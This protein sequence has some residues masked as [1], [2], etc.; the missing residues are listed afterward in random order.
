MKQTSFALA[1]AYFLIPATLAA[2][3]RVSSDSNCPSSDA[4][5]VRLLGLLAA[6]G[7]AAASARVH[8]DGQSMRIEVSTPGEEVRQ[9]T[10]AASGDCN[11]RAEMAA[12]IIAAWLDAMPVGTISTP[13]IP[14]KEA[15]PL[16]TRRGAGEPS[17]EIE[18]PF[19]VINTRALVG[20]GLFGLTDKQGATAG[21]SIDGAMPNLLETFGWSA[22]VQ[23]PLSRQLAI[24][25]GTAHYWRPTLG[26]GATG[27]IYAGKWVVR[28]KIGAELGILAVSGTGFSENRTALTVMWGADA[29]VLVARAWKRKELWLQVDGVAWPQDR[30]IRSNQMPSGADI[31]VALPSWELRV[32][33][34]FSWG[35]H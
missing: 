24:G 13:G 25:Q 32:G 5:S 11:E 17:D 30:S 15:R 1:L 18:E 26:L 9:R 31:L 29:G 12:L 35:V 23:L 33:V 28:A 22:Q 4:I 16:G 27:D 19:S 2:A 34:G 8:G 20:A 6:G 7:P 10:V 14:P 3:T 21:L